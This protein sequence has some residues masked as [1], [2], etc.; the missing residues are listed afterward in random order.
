[1]AE[2]EPIL[3]QDLTPKR[4]W[5]EQFLSALASVGVVAHAAKKAKITRQAAYL[6]R[7]ADPVFAARWKDAVEQSTELLEAEAIR[8]AST[9]TLKPVYQRGEL[10]GKIRE[11]SDTLLIF[12]LKARK[13]GMYRDNPPPA[14]SNP[15]PTGVD[16]ELVVRLAAL[17]AAQNAQPT[18]AGDSAAGAG[19]THPVGSEPGTASP[20]VPLPGR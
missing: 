3:T 7:D 6:A 13:P 20:G 2:P 12:M 8:R 19:E 10:V 16:I 5:K 17:L 4:P 14:P 15:L 1:M 9:G 11:Y 18:G